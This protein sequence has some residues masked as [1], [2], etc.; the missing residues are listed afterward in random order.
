MQQ[1]LPKTKF[2]LLVFSML[3]C[4]IQGCICMQG[5]F[6]EKT[7]LL[8]GRFHLLRLTAIVLI[9]KKNSHVLT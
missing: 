4:T 8:L 6:Y 7:S 3:W 5:K 1:V 2:L 9:M